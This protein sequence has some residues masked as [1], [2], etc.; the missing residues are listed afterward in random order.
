M[1]TPQEVA[2]RTFTK[3][4]FGGGYTMQEVDD[5]LDQITITIGC[6]KT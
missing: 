2:E 5:F 1:L 3:A 4:K 6:W